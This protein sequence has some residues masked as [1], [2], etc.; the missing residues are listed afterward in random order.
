LST[1]ADLA[2]WLVLGALALAVAWGYMRAVE[3]LTRDRE[4][5]TI[6]P[7]RRLRRNVKGRS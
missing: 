7:R 2:K 1:L 3:T 4:G 5:Q 6:E